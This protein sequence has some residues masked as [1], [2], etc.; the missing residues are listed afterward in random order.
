M[1]LFVGVNLK[2]IVNMNKANHGKKDYNIIWNVQFCKRGYEMGAKIIV[3]KSG[4][5]KT[6]LI[7]NHV[8]KLAK[9]G[10][11][12]L[13]LVPEQATLIVQQ[14][15]VKRHENHCLSN[16]EILSFARLTYRLEDDLGLAGQTLLSDMGKNMLIR[17]LLSENP[18]DFPF[19]SKYI[20]KYGYMDELRNLMGEYSRY[21]INE[22]KLNP[23][24]SQ[25]GQ[26][27][28]AM[29]LEDT[30]RLYERFMDLTK[31]GLTSTETLM[32][33][34]AGSLHRSDLMKSAYIFIDGFYGFTP[35]QY[36]MI[37]RMLSTCLEVTFTLTIDPLQCQAASL[38]ESSLYYESRMTFDKLKRM[39][40]EDPS[41]VFQIQSLQNQL[42]QACINHIR[43]HLYQYPYDVFEGPPTG[44]KLLKAANPTEEVRFVRDTILK[45]VRDQGYRYKDFGILTGNVAGYATGLEEAFKE[46]N[47]PLY[48]DEKKAFLANDGVQF[49]MDMLV[50]IRDDFDY[51]S[52]MA[53]L[54]SSFVTYD[55]ETIDFLENYLIRYG[56][57]GKS[58]WS[59]D[60][61][62]PH[63]NIYENHDGLLRKKVLEE[64]NQIRRSVMD[65]F[66]PCKRTR[67]GTIKELLTQVYDILER[68]HFSQK[69]E[70]RAD[71][72]EEAQEPVLAREY[73][74]IYRT[75]MDL[76][77][78][79]C[80]VAPSGT[81][82]FS[83][84]VNLLEAGMEQLTL[85]VVP[86]RLDQVV[87]G[88]V[89]RSRLEKRKVLFV[90]GVNEGVLP[91][92]IEGKGL[93][94]DYE[95]DR[96]YKMGLELAPSGRRTLF[97]DQ[98]YAYLGFLKG[99]D[100]LY[101]SYLNA[102]EEGKGLRP[103]HIIHMLRK[104][105]PRLGV[106]ELSKGYEQA[107]VISTP[108]A[109]Y[110]QALERLH[111]K[112]QVEPMILEWLNQVSPWSDRY[113][114]A[115]K[116]LLGNS[117]DFKLSSETASNLYPDR[118]A[119]SVTRL[120]E[121]AS[122]PFA[123]FVTYGLQAKE[124][125]VYEITM[126]QLGTIFHR[127]IELFFKRV[128]VREMTFDQVSEEIRIAWVE[129]LVDQVIGDEMNQVFFDTKRNHHR[130]TRLKAM[131]DK[132][133][134]VLIF[135]ICS[136]DFVPDAAEWRFTGD[137][138]DLEALTV[139]VKEK[140]LVL[141]GTIDRVDQ[142]D[143][144]GYRYLTLVDYKSSAHDVDLNKVYHGLQLQLLLYMNVAKEIKSQES[145]HKVIP[146]GVFY[147]K[148][149][150]PFASLSEDEGDDVAVTKSYEAMRLKGM[151][152]DDPTVIAHL[153]K[154]FSGKSLVIPVAKNKDASLAKASKVLSKE[155]FDKLLAFA[156]KKV[157]GLS[158]EMVDGVIE[159]RPYRH[160]KA[161]ACDHCAYQSA[162][163]FNPKEPG[164]TY[165]EV[166]R[167]N[168][169]ENIE[170]IKAAL[171]PEESK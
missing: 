152:I 99:T 88:D 26:S 112:Q 134:T 67:N 145:D 33:R 126:P 54:K 139:S 150:D 56:I 122:C 106:V 91:A 21:V 129:E 68:H 168:Q 102:D 53:Y 31:S 84:M 25:I 72:L 105:F 10:N 119:L 89:T 27:A 156:K 17:R 81:L 5:G 8:L 42:P 77:D 98:F 165:R 90:L 166:S 124:R 130:I 79:L 13:V 128:K 58:K 82:S 61:E 117:I 142:F 121:F 1:L 93:L 92:L 34:L 18:E 73:R 132:T 158:K 169:D 157:S 170:R 70:A 3:G 64:I 144:D 41:Q 28:L 149:D 75:L 127:V 107:L 163:R 138:E 24:M 125:D 101:V 39:V 44:L 83:D 60:F 123:H 69:L 95:R 48:V 62:S 96:L 161:S 49:L 153:D 113:Q 51:P 171:V 6:E 148:I 74:Q 45:L 146:S 19:L 32:Q 9:E 52:V 37:G 76:F 55:H 147:F 143:Q 80:Q 63:P 135:Q 46:G 15:L 29:K 115:R 16:I 22:D 2:K 116:G 137:R 14:D 11:R 120:E 103:S 164:H 131:L 59:K 94:S 104:L 109:T 66:E 47:M 108:H 36:E 133:L 35:I 140:K 7:Y 159:A 86:A 50:M 151:M 167:L 162:C 20:N 160:Q 65:M 87:V 40:E 136:G 57:R 23:I 100:K 30:F 154:E 71:R 110:R 78:Q 4:A 43:D 114:F 111:M 38:E 155:D 12:V 97:R 118:F 141:K 85:G